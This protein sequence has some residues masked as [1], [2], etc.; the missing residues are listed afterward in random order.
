MHLG[1]A[2]ELMRAADSPEG[3]L[4]VQ[5]RLADLN[6]I[7]GNY[8]AALRLYD[9]IRPLSRELRPWL[10]AATVLRKHGQYARALALIDEATASEA[11]AGTDHLPLLL[12][13]ARCRSIMGQLPAAIEVL[14]S[15]LAQA[16]GRRDDIVGHLLVQLARAENV[17]GPLEGALQH[18]KAAQD[19]FSELD[20]LRGLA[21]ALRVTGDAF[22]RM[23]RFDEAAA[24][25]R[26]GLQLAERVGSIDEIGGCLI[27]LGLAEL[28][29][30]T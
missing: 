24:E 20:D 19:I 3:M 17:R 6:E 10:G 11:L 4:D 22:S 23:K 26:R 1:R 9:G 27:N 5:L 2:L 28:G 16:D 15:A 18:G 13:K 21:T 8:D 25:L 14:S 30:V 7:V 29:G 12:E